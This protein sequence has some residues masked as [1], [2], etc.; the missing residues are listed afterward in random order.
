[1]ATKKIIETS[2]QT[3]WDSSSRTSFLW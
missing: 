2:F 1:V 3:C